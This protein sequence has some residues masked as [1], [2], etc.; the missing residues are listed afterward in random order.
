REARCTK[1]IL[2]AQQIRNVDFSTFEC[3]EARREI[4][5][6][7]EDQALDGRRLSPISVEGLKHEFHTGR[8]RHEAVRPS[9]DRRL[10]EALV[11]DLLDVLFRH[12]PAR[13]GCQRAVEDHEI[14]PWLVQPDPNA[15]W[16]GYF[17]LG[18]MVLE[19]GSEAT[20]VALEGE[21]DVL[22][23][24][25][26]AIVESHALPQDKVIDEAVGRHAPGLGQ[27]RRQASSRHR[28]Y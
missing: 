20:T 3:G 21:F 18:D 11:T 15:S 17:H 28:L 23:R 2:G 27:T 6:Y 26:L 25:R 9:A 7:S 24:D 10:L 14:G 1:Q 12:D 19:D 16:I 13:P 8:K 22:G 4:W 5:D